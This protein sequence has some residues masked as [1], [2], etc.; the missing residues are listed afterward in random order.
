MAKDREI[1]RGMRR[2]RVR[3]KIVGTNEQPRL[4]IFRSLKYT[5][6]QLI[7][8]ESGKVLLSSSTKVAK[9]EGKSSQC[10]ESAEELG[11]VIAN[12]A[13]EK[14]ISKIVF[15]RNG[16]LYHGRIKAV[17]DGARK[18]GLEF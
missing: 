3:K 12:T 2:Q 16:Y 6:A 17:A 9:R 14:N 18:G 5:Y 10:I 8:D 15:D 4:S 11:M 7:S 13:K 1:K